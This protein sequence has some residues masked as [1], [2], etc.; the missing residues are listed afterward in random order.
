M[1]KVTHQQKVEAIRNSGMTYAEIAERC[2][3]DTSTIFRIRQGSI[4]D[5]RYSVGLAIDGL[6]CGVMRKKAKQAA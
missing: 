6:Y 1:S 4:A 5:P 3:V 2:E